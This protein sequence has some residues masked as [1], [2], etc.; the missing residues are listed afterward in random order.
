[1]SFEI[2]PAVD[3]KDGKCVQLVQGV[4][5]TETISLDDPVG[6]AM[7][8]VKEGANVLHLVDLNGAIEGRRKNTHL[9]CQV[10]ERCPVTIQV[11]GGIRSYDDAVV[12]LDM[13]VDRI[14]LGTAAVENHMLVKK[15][16]DE[17]GSE[18]IMVSLDVKDGDVMVEGWKK[19]SGVKPIDIGMKFQ[20]LGAGFIFFTN[21]NVEGLLSG[22]DPEPIDEL[23]HAVDIPVIASGGVASLDD[24]IAIK[25]VGAAGA[26][27]GTALYKGNFTLKEAMRVVR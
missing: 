6:V 26:V 16:A 1:M 8:W 20:K 2:I 15:L 5:G 14:I 27:V 17:Y 22:V 23:V 25:G 10:R 18:H 12:L 13:G 24:L 3:I 7:R 21:I 11:G 9:I 4:P 19:S